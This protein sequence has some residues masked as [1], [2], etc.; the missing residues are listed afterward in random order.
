MKI[1]TSSASASVVR[2]FTIEADRP[3]VS[4]AYAARPRKVVI[5]RGEIRYTL[6][7]GEWVVKDIWSISISGAVLKNDGT[8]S[9]NDH[10]RHPG[11]GGRWGVSMELV[12]EFEWL[13]PII[14]ALR[15]MGDLLTADFDGIEVE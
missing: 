9:K 6:V 13:N 1:S 3:V 15:P 10:T 7:D 8:E 12:E 5:T 11:G 4:M 2:R 14:D